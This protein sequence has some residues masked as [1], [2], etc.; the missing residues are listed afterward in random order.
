MGDSGLSGDFRLFGSNVAGVQTAAGAAAA[1]V[2]NAITLP[3][4]ADLAALVPLGVGRVLQG[5]VE[6][7]PAMRHERNCPAFVQAC[8]DNKI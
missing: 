3:N 6:L 2:V 7:A 8:F 1:F 5:D 4:N